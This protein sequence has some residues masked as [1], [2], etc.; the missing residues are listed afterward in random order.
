MHAGGAHQEEVGTHPASGNAPRHEYGHVR[1]PKQH[2]LEKDGQSH[3][4]HMAARFHALQ[5]ES[6]G[7]VIKHTVCNGPGGGKAEY[8]RAATLGFLDFILARE[9][10]GEDYKRHLMPAHGLKVLHVDRRYGDEV[11]GKRLVRQIPGF[12][13]LPPEHSRGH[14]AAGEAGE[15][16]RIAH[17]RDQPGVAYPGHRP[18]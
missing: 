18:A 12:L 16:A 13:Y 1:H 14:V 4:A 15:A 8:L 5:D 3:A 6:V 2:L 11:H 7:T 9:T 10:P 17:G